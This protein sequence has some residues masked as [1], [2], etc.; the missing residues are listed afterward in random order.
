MMED[1]VAE[2]VR[3]LAALLDTARAV[4]DGGGTPEEVLWSLWSESGWGRRLEA[5]SGAGG[6]GGRQADRDL[7]AILALFAAAARLEERRPR[8]GV[9]TLLAELEAEQIPASAHEERPAAADAVRLLTAHR[10]KGLEWDLVVV[11]GVQDGVW[12]DLRRR[13]TLLDADL[14]SRDGA[15]LPATPAQ[16]LVEERRLFYVALTRARRRLVVTAVQSLDDAGERPSRF[17]DE[18]DIPVPEVAS[19]AGTELLAGASLVARLRR[20][21]REDEP[22]LRSAAARR[23]AALAALTGPDGAPLFPGADPGS[24]WG[25]RPLTPGVGPLRDPERPLVLSPSALKAFG[26]C[27]LRWFLER[28]ARARGAQGAA[29]GFGLVVHALAQLVSDGVL[30]PDR[31]AVLARLDRVWPSLGFEAPWHGAAERREAEATVDRLLTWLATR[32][33]RTFVAAEASFEAEVG[34]VVLRGSADRLD[35]DGDGL[36]HVVDFKTGRTMLS[37][38]AAESDPQLGAYQLAIREG[39]FEHLEP[40]ARPGGAELVYL[41]T[42]TAAGVPGSRRQPPVGAW[43]DEV[44]GRTGAAVRAEQFPAQPNDRC[45]ACPFRGSCPAQAE[46]RQVVS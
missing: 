5:A 45:G 19:L 4:L 46:G 33:D 25:I 7:D 14:V 29:Q 35:I 37:Y 30:P 10:A 23:L 42:G 43:M 31:D 27:P 18:L 12:P 24:W 2:P 3:R 9:P 26:E 11:T 40:D 28:E 34:G 36:V 1:W 16:L 8:A 39:G 22:G 32:G 20:S 38:D 15:G 17:L 13:G 21:L 44:V 6:S 41:R